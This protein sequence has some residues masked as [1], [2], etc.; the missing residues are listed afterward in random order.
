MTN[1]RSNLH[2]LKGYFQAAW[3]SI[4]GWG[5]GRRVSDKDW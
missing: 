3:S 5:I 2:D 1:G 4:V